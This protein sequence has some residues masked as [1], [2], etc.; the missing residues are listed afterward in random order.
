[1]KSTL[2]ALMLFASTALATDLPRVYVEA[3]ETVDASNAEHKANQVDFGA[4]ITAALVKKKCSRFGGH[5]QEQG[6]VDH[7]CHLISKGRF[8]SNESSQDSGS[9]DIGWWFHEVRGDCA[10]HRQ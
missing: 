8:D 1:M 3:T 4:A 7:Q 2:L 9:R 5:R 10:G 6:P